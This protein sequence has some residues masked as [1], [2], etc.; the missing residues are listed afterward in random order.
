MPAILS[1]ILAATAQ[2][3]LW[4]VMALGVYVTFRLLD[5]ADLTVDGSFATG[6]VIT[7]VVLMRGG[8]PFLALFI[9][10]LGGVA[11]GLITGFLNTRMHIPPLLASILT[12]IALYTINLRILGMPNVPL[13]NQR[14]LFSIL[15]DFGLGRTA[16]GLVNGIVAAAIVGV[17]MYWFFGTE[18]G[19]AIR[20]TGNNPVMVRE[21]GTNTQTTTLIGLMCGNALV[22]LSGSLVAQQQGTSD[23]T[24][25]TGAIV[26]GLASV[27]IGEVLLPRTTFWLRIIGVIVGSVIYRIVISLVLELPGVRAHDLKLFTA[28]IVALALWLPSF[29]SGWRQRRARRQDHA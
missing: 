23:V 27:I 3:L 7:A 20:A 18:I 22:A 6:G 2:G 5:F 8:S 28:I 17:L 1:S 29:S 16:T 13:L 25:G 9:A 21:L 10:L 4:A 14:T 15:E 19:A 24:M 11:A 26:I 12:Q